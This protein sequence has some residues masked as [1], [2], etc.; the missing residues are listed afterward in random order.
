MAACALIVTGIQVKTHFFPPTPPEPEVAGPRPPVPVEG[1]EE[2]ASVGHRVG[3]PNAAVTIVEFGDF[4]CP[5]C[6]NFAL[7]ALRAVMA[8]YPKDVALVHRHWPLPYH[9]F[10]YPAAKA[11]VCA[12]EQ[13]RFK[14][15]HD[16][17]YA[18]QDS[19]GLKTWRAFAET[20]GVPD[21]EA[22]ERC[23]LTAGHFA[24]IDAD[25][26]AAIRIGASG[27]P[28]VMVNGLRFS[29]APDSATLARHVEA[30]LREAGR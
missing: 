25:S 17:L 23:A 2:I 13:G 26:A 30:A 28:S 3:P 7:G 14:E 9:R 21:L 10:G 16:A 15:I 4:E 1:W 5:V 8:Q 19:L 18:G 6:R 20:A 22:F 29:G 27:T 12:S 24:G 11:A